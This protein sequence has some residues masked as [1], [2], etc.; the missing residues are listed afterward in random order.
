MSKREDIIN[1]RYAATANYGLVYTR[2]LGWL[3]LGH[4]NPKSDRP[5]TGAATL[6]REIN[7]GGPDVRWCKGAHRQICTTPSRSNDFP[8]VGFSDN[9]TG[10]KV[11]YRQQQFA[12]RKR[13]SSGINRE[14]IVRHKLSNED[15]KSVALAI[16]MEV[17]LEFE[18]HQE[19]FPKF[20]TDSG[21]SQEDLVSNLISFHIAIGTVTQAQVMALAEPVSQATAFQIWDRYG[22]VGSNKNRGFRPLFPPNTA[23]I[24]DKCRIDECV[25]V[26]PRIPEFLGSVTPAKK[27]ILFAN[28]IL[29]SS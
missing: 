1:E 3:D 28:N 24:T 27:G 23:M 4:M 14:Y 21:F 12:L 13:I 25:S 10:F 6:W 8:A 17:S 7:A 29:G 15:K 26:A 22:S 20:I 18:E 11:V 16:F 5:H 9:A 19:A 2:H